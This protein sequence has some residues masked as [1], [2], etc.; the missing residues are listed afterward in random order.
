ML[1]KLHLFQQSNLPLITSLLSGFQ[2]NWH[3]HFQQECLDFRTANLVLFFCNALVSSIDTIRFF[4]YKY[5]FLEKYTQNTSSIQVI[6]NRSRVKDTKRASKWT[7]PLP[8]SLKMTRLPN[9][10]CLWKSLSPTLWHRALCALW[11]LSFTPGS[12]VLSR[13]G[14]GCD[15]PG[16]DLPCWILASRNPSWW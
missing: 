13:T 15:S 6:K 2:Y 3:D 11:T 16:C 1:R 5:S 8:F 14:Q 7:K 10:F 4:P 9:Y 12:S